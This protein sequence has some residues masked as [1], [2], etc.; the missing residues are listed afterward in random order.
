MAQL[1]AGLTRPEE[2][3]P[4]GTLGQP[5]QPETQS[6]SSCS[7]SSPRKKLQKL[8]MLLICPISCPFL[9]EM[10]RVWEVRICPLDPHSQGYPGILASAEG[11]GLNTSLAPTQA[12]L[13]MTGQE[14]WGGQMPLFTHRPRPSWSL[15]K[16]PGHRSPADWDI[17]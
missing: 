9:L 3:S 7:G 1:G 12:P 14:L 16:V 15:S 11:K 4:G 8:Q 13:L 2:I 6:H 10:G 17:H 5:N